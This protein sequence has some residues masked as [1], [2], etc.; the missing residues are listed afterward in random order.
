MVI[1]KDTKKIP[2]KFR[3]LI[4]ILK[5]LEKKFKNDRLDV[6]FCIKKNKVY[7]LQSRPLLGTK[8]KISSSKIKEI[9]VNLEKK[10][11]KVIS[12]T[13]NL[14][15]STTILSNMSDW[16]PAEMIGSKP[17]KLASSLYSTLITNNVWSLQRSNYGY[18]DVNPSILMLDMSGN[19][20]IDVRTDL[21]SFLP[22]NLSNVVSEKIVN[23]SI[24][25]LKKNKNYHDK[26]EFNI[27]D[28]CYNLSISKNKYNFL[29]KKE[30]NEYYESLRNLT[31][32]IIKDKYLYKDLDN[33]NLLEEKI[34]EIKKTKLSHIQKIYY[35]MD[36]C[37]KYGTLAFAGIARC[38]FISKSILDSLVESKVLDKK[39][40][41]DFY[42]SVQTISKNINNEYI[43][44][45]KYNNF[46]NFLKKYGHLRPSTYSI[47]VKNY[48][49]NYKNI[50]NNIKI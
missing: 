48:T 13:K 12:P 33:I 29:S 34:I 16:N 49:E 36:D 3:E 14:L 23:N 6:E 43:E 35:L 26:I 18:K 47:S 22:K 37:K 31:N 20:Y 39:K 46:K 41:N 24:N 28:T 27:I 40:L 30:R 19:A 8:K 10:F 50:S 1:F 5:I 38:A 15:G 11:L 17:Y 25:K 2:T 32:K 9:I 42:L 7:I 4:R 44:A 45:L 21:N